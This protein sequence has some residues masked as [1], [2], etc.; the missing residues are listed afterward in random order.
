MWCSPK[1]K[2][3]V[4][5]K[6]NTQHNIS[7]VLVRRVLQRHKD[8]TVIYKDLSSHLK[9]PHNRRS[10]PSKRLSQCT[11]Q[12]S[13]SSSS[14]LTFSS[15]S[16]AKKNSVCDHHTLCNFLWNLSTVSECMCLY[17]FQQVRQGRPLQK[18]IRKNYWLNCWGQV[19]VVEGK[20]YLSG[21]K[22]YLILHD[23]Q[24]G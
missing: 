14:D 21:P 4:G 15:E 10:H 8:S 23:D 7:G 5:R 22:C 1:S 16:E 2:Q 17:L 24:V 3:W 11:Y 18:N 20:E 12:D 6:P 9:T 13:P 19:R